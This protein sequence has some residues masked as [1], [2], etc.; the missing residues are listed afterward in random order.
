MTTIVRIHVYGS[1]LEMLFLRAN[2]FL[3]HINFSMNELTVYFDLVKKIFD[4]DSM[5]IP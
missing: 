4:D 5:I 3:L 2:C 1:Y